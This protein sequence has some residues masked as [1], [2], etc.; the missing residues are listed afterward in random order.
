MVGLQTSFRN[1]LVSDGMPT[2]NEVRDMSSRSCMR[3]SASTSRTSA[4]RSFFFPKRTEISRPTG[5]QAEHSIRFWFAHAGRTYL[6]QVSLV[7]FGLIR[8]SESGNLGRCQSWIHGPW[9]WKTRLMLHLLNFFRTFQW[10]MFGSCS[11]QDQSNTQAASRFKNAPERPD[12]DDS[13][14]SS[15]TTGVG[16]SD[17]SAMAVGLGRRIPWFDPKKIWKGDSASHEF[18][19]QKE[20]VEYKHGSIS[21]TNTP[22]H[23]EHPA[24]P[25]EKKG[26]G[27][28]LGGFP[29]DLPADRPPRRTRTPGRRALP[30][31]RTRSS[32]GGRRSVVVVP[33]HGERTRKGSVSHI[34][35]P[36]QHVSS[37]EYS[38]R[39]RFFKDY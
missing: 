20:C 8:E 21:P 22:E 10:L 4:L 17:R 11:G 32:R 19:P 39:I 12:P 38:W 37:L 25:E 36:F 26:R 27:S 18:Q 24:H 28:F 29:A 7:T 30:S 31:R 23:P 1:D 15:D 16:S 3:K 13:T 9:S 5:R 14:G 6:F 2:W 33:Q 34:E 35:S